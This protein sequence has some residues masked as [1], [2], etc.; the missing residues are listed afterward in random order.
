[1]K[2]LEQGKAADYA[3]EPRRTNNFINEALARMSLEEELFL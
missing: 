2:R 3:A 1:M